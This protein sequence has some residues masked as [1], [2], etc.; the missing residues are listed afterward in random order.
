MNGIFSAQRIQRVSTSFACLFITLYLPNTWHNI[1]IIPMYLSVKYTQ[2]AR[3]T[4]LCTSRYSVHLTIRARLARA[5][6]IAQ[7]QRKIMNAS[8]SR[9]EDLLAHRACICPT[10]ASRRHMHTQYARSQARTQHTQKYV[11]NVYRVHACVCL[12]L[13]TQTP[14]WY[15]IIIDLCSTTGSKAAEM[16]RGQHIVPLRHNTLREFNGHNMLR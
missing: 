15:G 7:F 10:A 2:S 11:E 12:Y 16:D 1:I 8:C 5:L 9:T 13:C 14:R 3:F 6:F 4:S